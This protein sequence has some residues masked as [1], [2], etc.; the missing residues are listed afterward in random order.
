ML[1]EQK[2]K[3]KNVFVLPLS[4]SVNCF[5]LGKTEEALSWIRIILNDDRNAIR[6]DIYNFAAVFH[7]M[8]H[9]ELGNS[10]ILEYQ[11]LSLQ[12]YLAEQGKKSDFEALIPDLLKKMSECPPGK[13]ELSKILDK[14]LKKLR[15][16]VSQP[17]FES[18]FI[19]QY[20]IMEWLESKKAEMR[21][22]EYLQDFTTDI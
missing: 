5:I 10:G 17:G 18:N 15:D 1:C 13:K 7:L 9:Y 12:R 21:L 2:E 3:E 14:G 22:P 20:Y 11:A 16:I 6:N 4:I 19:K 8:I